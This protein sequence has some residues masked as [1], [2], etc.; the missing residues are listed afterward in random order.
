VTKSDRVYAIYISDVNNFTSIKCS[1]IATARITNS[2]AKSKLF[3]EFIKFVDVFDTEKADVLAAYNKNK[4][5]IN[6]DES[7]LFFK[8]LYNLS[9]K[10]LKVLKTYLNDALAK[11]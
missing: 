6:L 5:T 4:Y 9:I 3:I 11:G 7:K 10:E 8:P 1:I 2:I